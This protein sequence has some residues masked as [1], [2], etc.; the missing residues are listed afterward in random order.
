MSSLSSTAD[1]LLTVSDLAARP[2]AC[3]RAR[4]DSARRDRF[5]PRWAVNPFSG[6][7]RGGLSRASASAG[8]RRA[9]TACG[10]T[11]AMNVVSVAPHPNTQD[12]LDR[13]LAAQ[14][15]ASA[16]GFDRDTAEA[17]LGWLRRT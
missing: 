17:I 6:G 8:T 7:G 11:P 15:G 12:R 14:L 9:R 10:G 13:R 2:E 4:V 5:P 3:D 1:P 16:G